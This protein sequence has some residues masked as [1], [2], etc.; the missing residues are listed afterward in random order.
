M[1]LPSDS[2]WC[3]LAVAKLPHGH[4]HPQVG[5]QSPHGASPITVVSMHDLAPHNDGSEENFTMSAAGRKETG[6]IED[7]NAG[8]CLQTISN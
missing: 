3:V 8:L 2:H 7:S 5:L 6:M 4:G 1:P